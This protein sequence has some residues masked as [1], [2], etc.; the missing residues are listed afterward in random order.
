MPGGLRAPS[1]QS[2]PPEVIAKDDDQDG[3]FL[4]FSKWTS[5]GIT[6]K[7]ITS[8]TLRNPKLDTLCLWVCGWEVL[9]EHFGIQQG[10][11]VLQWVSNA[12][13]FISSLSADGAEMQFEGNTEDPNFQEAMTLFLEGLKSKGF[14]T[15]IGPYYGGTWNDYTKMPMKSV[16]YVNLQML[17]M[18]SV[19]HDRHSFTRFELQ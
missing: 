10:M 17:A 6:Y 11:S 13:K 14:L 5:Q 12:T 9:L 2:I 8:D 7:N 18:Y 3:N 15:A 19:T 4:P 1:L 16:D